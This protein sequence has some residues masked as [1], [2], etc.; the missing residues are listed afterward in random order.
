MINVVLRWLIFS[1]LGLYTLH[2]QNTYYV[3]PTGSNSSN[4]SF[5][6]PW[7]TLQ[8]ALLNVNQGDIVYFRD[9]I[10]PTQFAIAQNS[11]GASTPITLKNYPNEVPIIDG[12]GYPLQTL[13]L[14]NSKSNIVIDGLTFRNITGNGVRGLFITGSSSNIVVKNCTFTAINEAVGQNYTPSGNALPLKVCGTD[15]NLPITNISLINNHVY[16]CR[17]GFSE[18][19]SISGNVDGFLVEGN[20]VHD[21]TNIGI[22]AAGF[23]GDCGTNKQARNG[24][25]QKNTVFRCRFP[26][27][28]VNA[29]ASGIYIDGA[30]NVVA[31]RNLVYECQVGLQIG[32]EVI[33]GTANNDTLR[34][35]LAYNNDRWGIG[36]GAN[37]YPTSSGKVQS[38]AL[39]NNT[40]L[41]NASKN[42]DYAESDKY[43]ELNFTFAENSTVQNNIFSSNIDNRLYTISYFSM[44]GNSINYNLVFANQDI[45]PS[46]KRDFVHMNWATFKTVSGHDANSAFTDP[47]FNGTNIASPELH[48]KP[49]S[50]AINSGNSFFMNKVGI[51]DFD[52]NNRYFNNLDIGAFEYQCPPNYILLG[53]ITNTGVKLEASNRIKATNKITSNANATYQ[54]AKS[55]ELLPTFKTEPGAVFKAVIDGCGNNN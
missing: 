15:N 18:G 30:R 20:L 33:G 14:L 54:S 9:G 41:K 50:P 10:Y 48:L 21:I 28:S 6:S 19:I 53:D 11:G 23:Y 46:V 4:G 5:A 39:L 35:N 44:T 1:F 32:S 38:S 42:T 31:E 16:N 26:N 51:S 49:N 7:Q 12:S 45:T 34:S 3:S 29:T 13:L 22:V 17:T 2:A 8:H 43:G 27:L 47:Q 37:N 25:I 24:K 36:I 52:G 40:V 55:V